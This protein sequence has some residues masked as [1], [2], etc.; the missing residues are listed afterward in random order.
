MRSA[1]APNDL[2]TPR[3]AGRVTRVTHG[4]S[5]V[6]DWTT[7]P[8]NGRRRGNIVGRCRTGAVRVCRLV[9][10]RSAHKR[11]PHRPSRWPGDI[12]ATVCE[13]TRSVISACS[14]SRSVFLIAHWPV[15]R[16]ASVFHRSSRARLILSSPT[17]VEISCP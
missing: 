6:S 17:G 15:L 1:R 10:R 8:V 4:A 3:W 2:A 13:T 7:R 5:A 14:E 9:V 12:A 16:A 11:T